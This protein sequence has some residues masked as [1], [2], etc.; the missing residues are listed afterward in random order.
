MKF[1][2]QNSKFKI[3][4]MGTP[5]FGAIILKG[6]I[7]NNYKPVLVITP[8]DKPV[9]R[10]QILTSTPVKLVAQKYKIPV[11]QPEKVLNFKCN[12]T[13]S[14]SLRSI[15]QVLSLK[16]DLIISA[17]YGEIIPKEILK[18]P[19]YG[20]LN[21]HP[22]LLPKYRGPSPIQNT[23]LSGDKKTGTTIILIDEK[24]DHG[25]ILA[26]QELEF[27]IFP[28][29]ADQ[30]ETGNF[31]FSNKSQ[32]PMTKITYEELNK[33]LAELG[34]KLLIKTIP[35]W[36]NGEIKAKVQD[37]SKA[38]YTKII[39]KEDGKIDWKK[40]AGEIERQI[41]AFYPWPGTF[42]FF[43]KNNKTLRAKI[44]EAEIL[45]KENPKQLCIKCK[46]GYLAIKKLQPEG[47]KPMTAEDFLRGYHGYNPIL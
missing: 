2:I 36:I 45:D 17:A 35:K 43:K 14:F 39:K 26:Q 11:A 30:Q 32:S 3:I 13:G 15:Q 38:T 41:R 42:T 6:L 27:S 24:M 34:V 29:K 33:N 18:I 12:P 1:K 37:E 40:S 28:P 9:G 19:K 46:K 5:K 44:L 16:P 4:F 47:K 20:C 10:K 25:P 8:P 22:S 31:Q 23:I 7:K 21:I